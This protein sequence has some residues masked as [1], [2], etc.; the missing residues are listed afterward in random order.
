M[1]GSLKVRWCDLRGSQN[2]SRV[3][4]GRLGIVESRKGLPVLTV[5]GDCQIEVNERRKM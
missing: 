1:E 5:K 4:E 2:L 3:G